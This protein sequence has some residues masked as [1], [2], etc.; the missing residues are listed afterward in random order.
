MTTA[1]GLPTH[2]E[3]LTIARITQHIDPT[4]VILFGS[5]QRDQGAQHSDLDLLFIADSDHSP[6]ERR[7]HVARLFAHWPIRIDGLWLTPAEVEHRVRIGNPFLL[8]VLRGGRVICG[9]ATV[10]AALLDGEHSA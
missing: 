7:A 6:G 8:S 1:R 5:R 10:V 4:C 2:L 3:Q 9:D